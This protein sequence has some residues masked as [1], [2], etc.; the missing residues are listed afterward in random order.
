MYGKS[1]NV[2]LVNISCC[3]HVAKGSLLQAIAL[4]YCPVVFRKSFTCGPSQKKST[5][6]ISSRNGSN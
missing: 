4:I 2:V 5:A 1:I 3:R 6:T